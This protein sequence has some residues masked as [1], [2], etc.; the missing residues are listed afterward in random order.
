MRDAH[1][2]ELPVT[3]HRT[4]VPESGHDAAFDRRTGSAERA[5]VGLTGRP[6]GVDALRGQPLA[7]AGNGVSGERA[8]LPTLG[9]TKSVLRVLAVTAGVLLAANAVRSA[10]APASKVTYD[11][12]VLP[13]LREKCLACH[14]ADKARGGLS[15]A[16]FAKA[17]EG[18]GSGAVIEPGD[19]DASRLIHLISHQ[20]TPHMPPK[21]DRLSDEAIKV[22]REWIQGGALENSGSKPKPKSLAPSLAVSTSA[23]KPEGPPP[24]PGELTLDPALRTARGG[25][26]TALAASPWSPLFALAAHKQVFLY[27]A[28]SCE[29]LGVLAFPE[30]SVN[31]LRFSR[32]GKILLAAGGRGGASGRAVLFSLETGERLAEVGGEL[33]AVLAADLSPDQTQVALGGSSKVVRVLSTR[34]GSLI[35][36]IKKHTD[37]IFSVE[38]SPDGVLLA[39]ADRA[40]GL[41]VWEAETGREFWALRNHKAAINAVSWRLDSNVLAAA[42][43]EGKV[44]LYEMENGQQLVRWVA[45]GGGAL[46]L[47]FGPSGQL[48][49]SGRD[50]LVKL[51]DQSGKV[52]R[53][54]EPLGDLALRAVLSHD[55]SRVA[56]GDWTGETRV[57]SAADGK[58]FGSLLLNPPGLAERIEVAR[59]DLEPR[60]ARQKQLA[61]GQSQAQAAAAKVE[62]D[63]AG[64]QKGMEQLAA[65]VQADNERAAQAKTAADAA[66]SRL[67]QTLASLSTKEAELQGTLVAALRGVE[68]KAAE[69]KGAAGGIDKARQDL[70]AAQKEAADLASAVD[71]AVG[72]LVASQKSAETAARE[73]A[74]RKRALDSVASAAQ[75]A[76]TQANAAQ[77]Q[78]E[79]ASKEVEASK[80]ALDRLARA[81]KRDAARG[82]LKKRMEKHAPV[83]AALS[84]AEASARKTAAELDAAR[85][86]LEEANRA[87]EGATSRLSAAREA[88][89]KAGKA[90]PE[91]LADLAAKAVARAQAPPEADSSALAAAQKAAADASAA[92]KARTQEWVAVQEALAAAGTRVATGIASVK[93][94]DPKAR[95]AQERLQPAREAA[96]N[97]L[98]EVEEAKAAI[99]KLK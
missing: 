76:R 31:V 37:W 12:H 63:L 67:G 33:D 38:Y 21:S 57:W 27:H 34:D 58:R 77:T 71:K 87:L 52:L 45:H 82:E 18:G 53:E 51:W 16:A 99:E 56:G 90:V 22:F 64:A 39:T 69:D 36:E 61:D 47:H 94:L 35:R 1:Y 88:A 49:T 32:S 17:M 5:I 25:A 81:Q 92:L 46:S 59:R 75:T 50:R 40:N 83:L 30:G 97:P 80:A 70:A 20:K 98:R 89:A 73:A 41:F 15:L 74:G 19:A 86:Y 42:D 26:V 91:A 96:K 10:D 84:E 23:L 7:R 2:R 55:G 11:E 43:E 54:F 4:W 6:S 13:I 78:L 62:A 24:M 8:H 9:T 65:A 72:D 29:L 44:R 68:P 66:S 28:E 79:Q 93:A 85:K 3:V 60:L 95:Q 14:N 48:V